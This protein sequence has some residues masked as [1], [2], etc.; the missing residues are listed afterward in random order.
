MMTPRGTSGSCS[1]KPTRRYVSESNAKTW[2]DW[3]LAQTSAISKAFIDE[4]LGVAGDRR[5]LKDVSVKLPSTII[6]CT[7]DD[8]FGLA[9]RV[10]DECGW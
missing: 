9:S 7:T 5:T 1:W 8:A 6:S 3:A 2:C 4:E 10:L